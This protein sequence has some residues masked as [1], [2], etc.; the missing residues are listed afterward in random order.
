MNR[1]ALTRLR[2]RIEVL[3]CPMCNRLAVE[4]EPPVPAKDNFRA[5]Q[6]TISIRY[7]IFPTMNC[8]GFKRSLREYT[9]AIPCRKTLTLLGS[10]FAVPIDTG[11]LGQGNIESSYSVNAL[12][13]LGRS[14]LRFKPVGL[15]LITK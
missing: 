12:T 5:S 9:I 8:D 7:A 10:H 3:R 4:P 2:Q 6:E 11:I 13:G 1:A 14:H 15:A